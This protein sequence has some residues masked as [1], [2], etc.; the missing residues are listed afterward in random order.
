MALQFTLPWTTACS[1]KTMTLPGAET[2]KVGIIGVDCFLSRF[3]PRRVFLFP[4]ISVFAIVSVTSATVCVPF[5]P[6]VLA[7]ISKEGDGDGLVSEGVRMAKDVVLEL[8]REYVLILSGVPPKD[9]L[10]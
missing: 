1:P 8:D 10:F 3:I 5:T 6:F 2:I 9:L 4:L 7:D